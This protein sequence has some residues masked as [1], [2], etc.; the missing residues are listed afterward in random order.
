MHVRN[1][2]FVAMGLVMV[3]GIDFGGVS[4]LYKSDFDPLLDKLGIRR[5][6]PVDLRGRAKI[7]GGK[8]TL[9]QARC[10]AC[11]I[12]Y[13][14]CPTGVYEIEK[15]EHKKVVIKYPNLCEACE[16]CVLQCPTRALSFGV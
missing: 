8:I 9:N 14:V 1:L 15:G 2:F 7:T 4:P 6:G 16:A 5:I 12:C 11:E 13:D 3:I 10:T